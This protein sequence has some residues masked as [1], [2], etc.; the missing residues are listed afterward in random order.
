MD[1]PDDDGHRWAQGPEPCQNAPKLAPA[2]VIFQTSPPGWL[3]PLAS[4]REAESR[5]G[6]L[7]DAVTLVDAAHWLQMVDWQSKFLTLVLNF[8][9][10]P[11]RSS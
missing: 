4:I 7:E 3:L 6:L 5:E 8:T 2:R 9:K 10:D 1:G 11:S